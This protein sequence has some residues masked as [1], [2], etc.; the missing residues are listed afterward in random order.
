ME[1]R[2]LMP[3]EFESALR[4]SEYAF[5]FRLEGDDR[6][7]ARED[8]KP[9]QI[10][11]IFEEGELSAKLSLLPLQVYVQG[12]TISM[13][14]IAGVATWPESRRQGH[15]S[16]LLAHTLRTMNE[17]GQILS[18]LHPFLIPFYRNFGWEVY[19]EYKKY[20]IPVSKFPSKTE[21]RGSVE[22]GKAKLE[23]LEQLYSR[24]ASLYNG[25]LNRE[26][27]WW[28]HNVLDKQA[29]CAV[30][31]S[32]LGAPE[33]YVLYKIEKKEL[34]V[35]EF[36]YLNDEAFRGLWT[37]LANHDSMVNGVVMNMVPAD[38]MLPFLLAD[39]RIPQENHPY[40]MARVV[41]A[42]ALVESLSFNLPGQEQKYTLFI[43]DEHAP[44]NNGLWEWKVNDLGEAS[45]AKAEGGEE[46]AEMCCSI[47]TLAVLLLG[48]KRPVELARY[49]RLTGRKE[50][51]E[52][53]ETII[54][55]AQTALFDFF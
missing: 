33:G 43:K 55:R 3:E 30:Y 20:T 50:A 6:V 1:I 31:Y 40:F 19:C 48:Y 23:V 2:Q 41:N 54:P 32:A 7:R 21:Q 13:G 10:W 8:F 9:E 49:G 52:W 24:F 45:F 34:I 47:G 14:G 28:E 22:R 46:Q 42:K 38:D 44:W 35:D 51:V 37:F 5:Q 17:S 27:E 39:P 26:Q 18:F 16:R 36:I 29:H 4:L 12:K 11:G 15:V 53:L 25:T